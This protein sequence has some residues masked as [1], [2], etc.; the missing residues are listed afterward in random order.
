MMR[1]FTFIC[2]LFLGTT[3]A[4]NLQLFKQRVDTLSSSFMGGR[5]YVD[6]TD[7]IAAAYLVN[8]YE[9]I[10]LI[11]PKEDYL[12]YFP[13]TVNTFPGKLNLT[14]D[15]KALTPGD[16]FIM[17][18][19]SGSGKGSF[20]AVYAGTKKALKLARKNKLEDKVVIFSD[21]LLKQWKNTGDGKLNN[22]GVY[23]RCKAFV[24][25]RNN[26]LT[27]SY[28]K[29]SIPIPIFELSHGYLDEIKE[30]NF[31][32]TNNLWTG[33]SQN[34]VGFIE[35]KNTDS[36][37]VI[38]GHYDHLGKMGQIFFPGANDNASGVAIM[39]DLAHYFKQNDSLLN[40]NLMFIAFGGEEAG[41]VGSKYFVAHPLVPLNQIKA[42]I[43]LDL[44][45]A[46]TK[47][48]TMVNA[49]ANPHLYNTLKRV[50]N[51]VPEI[52]SRKQAA[53]SDHYFFDKEGVPSVFLYT[54]GDLTAYH[55]IHD[56]PE[57]L[58]YEAY[59]NVFLLLRDYI[60][61]LMKVN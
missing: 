28:A 16:D 29:E 6:R 58:E 9:K 23:A 60:I 10:G 36:T 50:N 42:Q 22:M 27:A 41:L 19:S 52:K 13:I 2:V 21:S 17:E 24:I 43:T 11:P 33:L 48:L 40:Y 37:I 44:F 38:S 12:Q 39:L 5:G 61:E 56:T 45:G 34:V 31:K 18:A 15:G 3:Y 26:K 32:V 51:Y 59:N 35:G 1:F 55:D 30:V 14:F 46:G 7:S 8:E 47:G 20:E 49:P 57:K 53:N 4:Q 54:L 25:F